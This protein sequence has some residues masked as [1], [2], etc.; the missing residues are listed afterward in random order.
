MKTWDVIIIGGGIVGV[1]LG[2]RL[3][4]QGARVLIVDRS[5]PGRE[6]SYAA[7]GMIAYCDHHTPQI[8]LPLAAASAKLY[9]EFVHELQD[10]SGL[11]IDYRCDGTIS[12]MSA[13]ER[14]P[15]GA[16]RELS[17]AE[18]KELEAGLEFSQPGTHAMYLP[19]AAVDPRQLITAALKAAKHRGIEVA[20]GAPVTEVDVRNGAAAGVKTTKTNYAAPVVVNCAGAW[21]AEI[22]PVRVPTRPIKGQMLALAQP[23][24]YDER[25]TPSAHQ[26]L[27]HVVR[28]PAQVYMVPRSDGRIIVGSTVEDVGFDKRVD[29]DTIQGLR[30]LATNLLP[31]LSE[32]KMLESWAGLRPG[33]PDN[34]PIL[35]TAGLPGYFVATGHYRDGILL[36]P[37]TAQV[38]AQVIGGA[39]P[40]FDLS[41]FALARFGRA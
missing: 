12:F 30:Q 19:E 20:F 1:S 17:P 24:S 16:A 29:T 23:V 11:R 31:A 34:L 26:V 9:P 8:L 39:T 38:M 5:E 27:R 37:I 2:L 33:T 13:E 41:P 10:E 14:S 35:G 6:A 25:G 36:S 18:V 40:E 28:L 32:A 21:A 4:R 7:A 15:C 22:G 3:R